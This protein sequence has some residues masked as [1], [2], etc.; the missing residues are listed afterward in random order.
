MEFELKGVE[1]VQ[2][3]IQSV[4]DSLSP[5]QIEEVLLSGA[6][7]VAGSI[8][9]YAPIAKKGHYKIGGKNSTFLAGVRVYVPPGNLKRSI[10]SKTLQRKGNKAA[11]AIAAVDYRI[12]PHAHLVEYGTVRAAPHPFFRPGY[13]A[14]KDGVAAD[15][16]EQFKTIIEE[17]PD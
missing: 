9:S 17:A 14:V 8:R 3:N 15:I 10:V 7:T 13:D 16:T 11:P 4:I 5:E 1:D 12:A 6:D 2:E